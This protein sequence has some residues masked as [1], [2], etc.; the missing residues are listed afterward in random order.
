M[1]RWM[2]TIPRRLAPV[3]LRPALVRGLSTTLT[4]ALL[5]AL[6]Q[7]LRLGS[8]LI[9]SGPSALDILQAALFALPAMTTVALPAGLMIGGLSAFREQAGRGRWVATR[10]W[11]ERLSSAALPL[12]FTGL[13]ASLLVAALSLFV[14]PWGLEHLSGRL[15]EVFVAERINDS[16]GRPIAL[17][18]RTLVAA[19]HAEGD[20]TRVKLERGWVLHQRSPEAPRIF[21]TAASLELVS[22]KLLLEG[23]RIHVDHAHQ[24][25][26]AD[27]SATLP[28]ETLMTTAEHVEIPL[29]PHI[30]LAERSHALSRWLDFVPEN[31]R[32]DAP[33]LL[34][35]ARDEPRAARA[36]SKRIALIFAPLGLLLLA[37]PLANPCR[38]EG[39][40]HAP[41][42]PILVAIASCG[43]YF[44]LLR[45]GE[46]AAAAGATS[47]APGLFPISALALAN[48]LLWSRLARKW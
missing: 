23:A 29:A 9:E 22:N 35:A 12:L 39:H 6:L 11:G 40:A 4:L 38:L 18:P 31:E 46:V 5:L 33:A 25:P 37:F 1:T 43:A 17:G 14:G 24:S 47:V 10:L 21:A 16:P 26:S 27:L 20:G 8:V 41:Y 7:Y 42:T 2:S 48:L 15:V 32:R 3:W 13:A 34:E 19:M 36:L 44:M 45:A 30:P 28:A